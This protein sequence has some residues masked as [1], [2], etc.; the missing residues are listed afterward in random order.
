MMRSPTSRSLRRGVVA[1]AA[2]PTFGSGAVT[3]AGRTRS[4]TQPTPPAPCTTVLSVGH[5]PG[6]LDAAWVLRCDPVE[7]DIELAGPR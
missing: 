1:V 4:Q 2:V 5:V 3:D 7:D 6:R